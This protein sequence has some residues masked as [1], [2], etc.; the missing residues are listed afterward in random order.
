MYKAK[1]PFQG[2]D[3]ELTLA[4]DEIVELVQK[5]DNGELLTFLICSPLKLLQDGG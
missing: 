3:G 4:K 1:Y 5:D 2:Q